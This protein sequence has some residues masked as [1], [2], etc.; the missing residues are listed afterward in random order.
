MSDVYDTINKIK[1]LKEEYK[2]ISSQDN[3][4]YTYLEQFNDLSGYGY[5]VIDISDRKEFEEFKKTHKVD[6]GHEILRKVTGV[7]SCV[8][9]IENSSGLYNAKN[10]KI[11]EMK[12]VIYDYLDVKDKRSFD[13]YFYTYVM[14]DYVFFLEE[15][16]ENKEF[17]LLIDKIKG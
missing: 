1:K 3:F 16:N 17:H 15:Y 6:V 11:N 2:K 10:E 7:G 4:T 14:E 8:Y 9:V 12:K 5:K 13:C